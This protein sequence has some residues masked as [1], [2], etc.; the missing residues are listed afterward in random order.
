MFLAFFFFYYMFLIQSC[1]EINVN[2][3]YSLDVSAKNLHTT[4]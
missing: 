1:N 2:L 3:F 4:N